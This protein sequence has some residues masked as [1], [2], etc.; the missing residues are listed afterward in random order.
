[1]IAATIVP[2]AA[3]DEA[4]AIALASM[5][6]LIVGLMTVGAGRGGETRVR[7]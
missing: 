1:M 2:L 5:L 3:G 4:L 7:R 6:A